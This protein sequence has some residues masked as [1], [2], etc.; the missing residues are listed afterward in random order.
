MSSTGSSLGDAARKGVGLVHRTGETIPGNG[1]YSSHTHA[2]TSAS[3]NFG[4]YSTNTDNKL[5]PRYD[6][7]FSHLWPTESSSI[8][9]PHSTSIDNKLNPLH[10]SDID[11]RQSGNG[12]SNYGPH[13]TNIQDKLDPR[14]DSDRD[15]RSQ[16]NGPNSSNYWSHSTNIADKMNPRYESGLDDRGVGI[17]DSNIGMKE[18]ERTAYN[19]MVGSVQTYKKAVGSLVQDMNMDN[20]SDQPPPLK[21]AYESSTMDIIKS[22]DNLEQ[23]WLIGGTVSKYNRQLP[24]NYF[25]R[26]DSEPM[27]Y[28]TSAWE[29][30]E[31]RPP[32]PLDPRPPRS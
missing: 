14:Y 2:A 15:H 7:D 31:S 24:L 23:A 29:D 3:T 1:E 17:R 6:S 22:E 28:F 12:S 20:E 5:D 4:P 30:I 8:Y 9:G 10:D 13:K 11:H 25:Q 18:V 21:L 27:P 16:R 32:G 26:R 19:L